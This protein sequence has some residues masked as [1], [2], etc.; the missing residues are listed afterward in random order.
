MVRPFSTYC[1]I[2]NWTHYKVCV[3]VEEGCS[4]P[5]TCLG[6]PPTGRRDAAVDS[7][8]GNI[9]CAPDCLLQGRLKPVGEGGDFDICL[10]VVGVFRSRI[11]ARHSWNTCRP[12]RRGAAESA[13][14]GGFTIFRIFTK[15]I[16]LS[17]WRYCATGKQINNVSAWIRRKTEWCR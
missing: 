7:S 3:N 4:G 15:I 5:G 6:A 16:K 12:S 10:L 2:G 13:G 14:E 17:L 9:C 11:C 8:P 1:S